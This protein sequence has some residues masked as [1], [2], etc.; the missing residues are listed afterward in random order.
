MAYNSRPIVKVKDKTFKIF[1]PYEEI[2]TAI[3]AVAERI[4][5]DYADKEFD[6]MSTSYAQARV[7]PNAE[8]IIIAINNFNNNSMYRMYN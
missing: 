8:Y 3:D 6:W 2:A 1:K 5:A 4:E 7:V